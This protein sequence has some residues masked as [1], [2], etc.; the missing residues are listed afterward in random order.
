MGDEALLP[1]VADGAQ[2]PEDMIGT[3]AASVR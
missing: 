2:S 3:L 1:G